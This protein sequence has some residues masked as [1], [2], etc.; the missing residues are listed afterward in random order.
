MFE[1]ILFPGEKIIRIKKQINGLSSFIFSKSINFVNIAICMSLIWACYEPEN[2]E[3]YIRFISFPFFHPYYLH[4]YSLK[5][6]FLV[7][8]IVDFEFIEFLF[9]DSI[10]QC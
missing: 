9:L 7:D 1:H 10:S 2:K 4:T 3:K 8:N 6:E 5:T